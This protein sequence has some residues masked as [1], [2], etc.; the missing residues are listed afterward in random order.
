MFKTADKI[1]PY[2]VTLMKINEEDV[3]YTKLQS[4]VPKCLLLHALCTV[5]AYS[6]SVITLELPDCICASSFTLAF[7]INK[8]D[9]DCGKI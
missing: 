6:N 4:T 7:I 5:L 3:I 9:V 8:Y 2:T 1:E